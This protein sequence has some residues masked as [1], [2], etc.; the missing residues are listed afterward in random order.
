MKSF[1]FLALA[2]LLSFNICQAHQAPYT[3]IFVDVNTKKVSLELQIPL[4]ELA[5]SF[6]QELLKDPATVVEQYGSRLGQYLQTHIHAYV[7][8]D[9]PWD[10]QLVDMTMDRG[11]EPLS[12]PPF[13]ELRAHLN[14][15]PNKDDD[16]RK[17][18]LDYDVVMHQVINH[19]ALVS[20]RTDWAGGIISDSAISVGV[21]RRDMRTNTI[22]PFEVTL[23]K[24]GSWKGFA[25]MFSL[26][27]E[28]IKNGTDHLLFIITLLLPAC[29]VVTNKRWAGYGGFRYSVFRLLQIITAFTIGHSITLLIGVLG[30]VKIPSQWVEITIAVSILVSAMHAI[31]PMFY[32]RELFI[33]LGF[34][35]IHGLAFS[36]TLQNLHLVSTD[37]ALSVL[38]FNLGIEAMQVFVISITIPWFIIMSRT[39][40]FKP[41]KNVFAV[42]TGSAAIGL[43]VQRVTG[44]DNLFSTATDR[45][46]S[47]SPWLIGGLCL[48]SLILLALTK[49]LDNIKKPIFHHAPDRRPSTRI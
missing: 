39:N 24:G 27:M 13:W 45:L 29:L 16:T 9:A 7:D 8:K 25:S 42:L 18:F 38:G 21:I 1:L 49:F 48:L 28:H 23:Q 4:P 12:G 6:G 31:R 34:G 41:V 26:G 5:L 11:T 3:N 46:V 19:F 2:F 44:G 22:K 10:I 17:F 30:I 20:I 37:L 14:L 32:G 43:I 33:A 35:L 15:V 47:F 36:Q 40:Y